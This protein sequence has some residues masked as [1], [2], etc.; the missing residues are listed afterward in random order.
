MLSQVGKASFDRVGSSIL[1]TGTSEF[2]SL[3]INIPKTKIDRA[4]RQR[5]DIGG[6]PASQAFTRMLG[7]GAIGAHALGEMPRVN[8]QSTIATLVLNGLIVPESSQRAC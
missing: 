4:I 5:V 2:R 3:A 1:S 8:I 6:Y 7:F